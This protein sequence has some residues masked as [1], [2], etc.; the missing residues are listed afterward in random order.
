MSRKARENQSTWLTPSL[1]AFAAG[2][3]PFKIKDYEPIEE[4]LI[5]LCNSHHTDTKEGRHVMYPF[6]GPAQQLLLQEPNSRFSTILVMDIKDMFETHEDY[7]EALSIEIEDV[8]LNKRFGKKILRIFQKL[9]L[10]K[11]IVAAPGDM[12]PV[13]LKLF[14]AIQQIDPDMISELWLVHPE[15][16][17]KYINTH[18]VASSVP[19]NKCSAKLNIIRKPSSNSRVAVLKHFFSIGVELVME[20]EAH[21][22]FSAIGACQAS[23]T[24]FQPYDPDFCNDMGSMLFMSLV[25]VEMNQ[26]SKQYD[27]N[28]MEITSDLLLIELPAKEIQPEEET[29]GDGP[30][31]W[32]SCEHHVGALVLRGNRCVLARSLSQKWKGMRIPSV[33]P[34]EDEAPLDAAI[35]AVVEFTEVEATEVRALDN[36]LPVSVYGPNGRPILVHLYPLYSTE[37]PPDGPLEDADLEDDETPYDW[38]TYPNVIKKLDKPSIAAL[39]T[40]ALSLVQAANV[41]L[42]PAKWGGVFGHELQLL[43]QQ[44]AIVLK[45]TPTAATANISSSMLEV[46]VEEW[47]PTQQENIILLDAIEYMPI[48]YP[49]DI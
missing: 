22:T 43:H 11:V 18:L 39:Q 20:E 47:K 38:Y 23:T 35:R 13:L 44:D 29:H 40:M 10:N 1:Y 17:T 34:K 12:C 9:L 28:C 8:E 46:T 49:C 16:S 3:G 41:G 42:V 19:Q 36:I 14:Q 24:P 33:V 15:L 26:Y 27:R 31:D 48:C 37:P 30:V 32:S 21:R 5:W 6:S 2:Y 7:Q 4:T 45:S 25:K